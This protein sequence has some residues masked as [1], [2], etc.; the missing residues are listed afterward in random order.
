MQHPN[1]AVQVVLPVAD[2]ATGTALLA[3]CQTLG[4][5]VFVAVGQNLFL[6]RFTDAL[7]AVAASA[8]GGESFD[9]AVVVQAGATDLKRAVPA[10]LLPRVLEGYSHS[11]TRGPF[12]AALIVA[13]LAVPA[14]LAMEWR[15]V[16]EG[17]SPS[18][19]PPVRQE[20]LSSGSTSSFMG[21]SPPDS[22]E[23]SSA[24]RVAAE[25]GSGGV[26]QDEL[27]VGPGEEKTDEK[28]R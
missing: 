26:L 23:E 18:P 14:A 10:A 12:F 9:P 28:I 7:E 17:G 5:A 1:L 16:K 2:I 27:T 4:G 15:S 24:T 6:A 13:C 22:G 21:D 3:V 11:L 20:G 19:P 25:A 8:G